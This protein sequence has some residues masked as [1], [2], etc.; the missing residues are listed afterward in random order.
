VRRILTT[1]LSG[2]RGGVDA[3]VSMNRTA[4][5]DAQSRTV[6]R[7]APRGGTRKGHTLATSARS[8]SSDRS[9][10]QHSHSRQSSLCRRRPPPSPIAPAVI[11]PFAR[12]RACL[13]EMDVCA[14]RRSAKRSPPR[15][16][17]ADGGRSAGLVRAEEQPSPHS[18]RGTVRVDPLMFRL[19]PGLP[20]FARATLPSGTRRH[21]R[22]AVI[23]AGQRRDAL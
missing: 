1:G 18:R 9:R 2:V 17:D 15:L 11:F 6:R 3:P 12:T 21:N 16:R 5:L 13:F 19:P 20:S 4:V 23:L 14:G 8:A 10:R 22:D 7:A